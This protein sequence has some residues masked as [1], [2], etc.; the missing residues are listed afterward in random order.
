MI[1]SQSSIDIFPP[2]YHRTYSC[3]KWRYTYY[4]D[5]HSDR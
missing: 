4:K 5:Y 3:Y 1:C 2:L